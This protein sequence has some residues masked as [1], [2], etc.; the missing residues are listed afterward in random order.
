MKDRPILFSAPMVRAIIEGRKTM[1]RRVVKPQPE[2][3]VNVA[4]ILAASEVPPF[5][6]RA[7]F[8]E[9][10]PGITI[11]AYGT[12]VC[13]YGVPG[14][15]LW[16]R[17][18]SIISPADFCDANGSTHVDSNGRPRVVQY[19]ASF[20]NTEAAGWYGLK[21][22]PS[23]FMPRWASRI[24][25]EVTGVRVERLQDIT[26][27]DAVAEG[28]KPVIREKSFTVVCR[29]GKTFEVS[30]L[31][32][33]GVPAV[34]ESVSPFGE[35]THVEPI[36]ERIICTAREAFRTLWVKINGRESWDANPWVWVVEFRMVGGGF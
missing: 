28:V 11:K 25:L 35:V 6:E 9:H 7:T 24:T 2:K 16:V 14:D 17:E 31:Y 21:K 20:P 5:P 33:R 12:R 13:P 18:T 32:E 19:I 3:E 1:T 10:H 36:P 23:I 22:T 30:S 27:Q 15:R 26:E 34:G 29:G 8:I 4:E